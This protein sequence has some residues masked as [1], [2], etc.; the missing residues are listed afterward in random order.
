MGFTYIEKV[1]YNDGE[2]ECVHYSDE[3]DFNIILIGFQR[4]S[5]M[6][7]GPRAPELTFHSKYTES[8]NTGW[9]LGLDVFKGLPR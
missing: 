8:I 2:L 5:Y 6:T 7:K 3:A 9:D 4:F 1:F